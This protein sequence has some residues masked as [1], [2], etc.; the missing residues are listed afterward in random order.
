MK[1]R[2]LTRYTLTT[3][4]IL[5]FL[6]IYN[7]LQT[8]KNLNSHPSQFNIE[9][10][11]PPRQTQAGQR[12]NLAWRLNTSG[13]FSTTATTI[14]WSEISSPSAL[15]KS[16]SPQ[17]VGYPNSLPDYL[18]GNFPLP[19]EFDLDLVFEKVGT[20]FYRAY[21]KIGP[22]HYWTPEHQIKVK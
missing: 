5:L 18:T 15:A 12:T 2:Q 21:A 19:E 4:L 14:Y 13:S 20:I 1:S 11:N 16:D 17:A 7:Y 10:V 22:D 8:Q 3:L 6:V 9:L